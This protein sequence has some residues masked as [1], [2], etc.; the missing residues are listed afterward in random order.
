M[1]HPSGV[2]ARSSEPL[3]AG[4]TT[5][6]TLQVLVP[7]LRLDGIVREQSLEQSE[8]SV[9]INAPCLPLNSAQRAHQK[10]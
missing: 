2:V 7:Y 6:V 3:K 8:D 1:R 9:E 4:C 10:P 5:A